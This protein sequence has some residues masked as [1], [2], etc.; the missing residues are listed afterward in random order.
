MANVHFDFFEEDIEQQLLSELVAESIEV[1]GHTCFYVPRTV[2]NR[3]DILSEPEFVRFESAYP[4]NV[5]IKTTSHM[6]GEGALLS[7]FGVELRDELIVTVAMLTFAD[8]ITSQRGDIIRPREGD[9]IFIPMIGS[10][11]TLKYVD[12]KAFFY[13]LGNLQAW[14]LSLELYEDANA[15]FRTGV[16]QID[17]VYGKYT[18]DILETALATEDGFMLT[19]PGDRWVLEWENMDTPKDDLEQNVEIEAEADEVIEWNEKD[20]FSVGGDY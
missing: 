1:N 3:D 11:F 18:H 9:L 14:D 20:P 6:G 19:E 17:S 2:V 10:A 16:A 8:E 15:V 13:Q 4:I 12:K 7:K 5:F